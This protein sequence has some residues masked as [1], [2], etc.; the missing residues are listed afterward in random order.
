MS[1][2]PP[3]SAQD[4]SPGPGPEHAPKPVPNDSGARP[5]RR[6]GKAAGISSPAV[7]ERARDLL[8][9]AVPAVS[10]FPRDLRFTL[11]ERIERRLYA[12]L[13]G[14]VR[15]QY[16][17]PGDKPRL[18]AAVNV[19]LQVL[20]HEIRVASDLHALSARQVEHFAR[21]MDPVGRQVGGW[22][23]SLA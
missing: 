18:L 4:G 3:G 13:E 21:L 1:E 14:L 7:V 17:P 9:W 22:L 15:A 20:R 8:L 6:K 12:V 5:S 10:K 19:D 11:G 23:R 2:R 16:A